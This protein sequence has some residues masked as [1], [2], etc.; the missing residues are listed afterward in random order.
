MYTHLKLELN[1]NSTERMKQIHIKKTNFP[2][3]P[4]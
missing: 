1:K 3:V 2:F 4:E